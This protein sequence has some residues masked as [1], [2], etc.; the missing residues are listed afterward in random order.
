MRTLVLAAFLAGCT[1]ASTPP[2]VDAA[3]PAPAA[4]TT[5]QPLFTWAAPTEN[6]PVVIAQLWRT[7]DPRG[8]YAGECL[9]L[10]QGPQPMAQDPCVPML[11]VIALVQ[12]A[13]QA[14]AK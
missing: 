13:V 6:G 12:Q 2:A 4:P 8:A 14:G 11:T 1:A 5:P 7:Y 9:S 10:P 3:P